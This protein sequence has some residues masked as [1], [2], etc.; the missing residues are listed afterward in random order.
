MP[1]DSTTVDAFRKLAEVALSGFGAIRFLEPWILKR[2]A[3]AKAEEAKVLAQSEID[4]A[5]LR[6]QGKKELQELGR[7]LFPPGDVFEA[8]IV[9]ETPFLL[10]TVRQRLE[11]QEA[12]RQLN[13]QTV[14]ALAAN[15]LRG[16]HASS[17][18]VDEDW[19]VR[20]FEYAKDVSSED[21]QTIWAKILAGEVRRPS[22]FSLRCL[23]IVRNLSTSEAEAFSGLRPF[24]LA[25]RFV[26]PELARNRSSR[27]WLLIAVQLADTG[28]VLGDR[29][30]AFSPEFSEGGSV[31]ISSSDLIV[32]VES[33]TKRTEQFEA[34]VLSV[35]GAELM[36][37]F[38]APSHRP[39]IA[40]LVTRLREEH[41]KVRVFPRTLAD[42]ADTSQDLFQIDKQPLP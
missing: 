30:L 38:S 2:L 33:Q 13:A 36:P 4:V 32:R 5:K 25:D 1:F 22:S 27:D 18:P 12:K 7:N 39:Y 26:L 14:V 21:M 31:D 19:T 3:R 15:E 10:T 41:Y 16:H 6:L 37:L 24:V 29:S 40:N 17:Q 8:E 34:I 20:F 42:R 23:D 11:L 9:E 35:V 28:L